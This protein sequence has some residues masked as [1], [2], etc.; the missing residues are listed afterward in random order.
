MKNK[1]I[2][3]QYPNFTNKDVVIIA[4]GRIYGETADYKYDVAVYD[5]CYG[6]GTFTLTSYYLG[7]VNIIP[8]NSLIIV[9]LGDEYGN[10]MYQ[11]FIVNRSTSI[12]NV[13]IEDVVG[14]EVIYEVNLL[15]NFERIPDDVI[16]MSGDKF[17]SIRK[18][19]KEKIKKDVFDD[20]DVL[21]ESLINKIY[22]TAMSRYSKKW[23][24]PRQYSCE[25]ERFYSVSFICDEWGADENGIISLEYEINDQNKGV[26]KF[27]TFDDGIM[28]EGSV[29]MSIENAGYYIGQ[30]EEDLRGKL[31]YTAFVLDSF[32]GESEKIAIDDPSNHRTISYMATRL[33][34]GYVPIEVEQMSNTEFEYL[35][36]TYKE[37][38]GK[39]LFRHN[40]ENPNIA[41]RMYLKFMYNYMNNIKKNN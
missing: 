5:G 33:D 12:K 19:L 14:Y 15:N 30:T 18:D 10:H 13:L 21:K 8:K 2:E 4:N 17:D 35:R 3:K 11:T 9:T 7:S 23:I 38:N 1:S 31:K 16:D 40:K 27:K 36:Y 34:S 6:K 24:I 20:K 26:V 28:P 37:Q 25:C 41:N 29:V 32:I 39:D 22:L